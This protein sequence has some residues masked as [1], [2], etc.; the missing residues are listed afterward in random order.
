MKNRI[1]G[2]VGYNFIWKQEKYQKLSLKDFLVIIDTSEKFWK[3]GL[4]ESLPVS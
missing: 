1:N 4:N 3:A 2:W